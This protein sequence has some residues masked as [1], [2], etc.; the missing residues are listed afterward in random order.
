MTNDMKTVMT[1]TGGA[2]HPQWLND[3]TLFI[4]KNG[5]K[6]PMSLQ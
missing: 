5:K 6:M 4:V 3:D 2:L 1:A